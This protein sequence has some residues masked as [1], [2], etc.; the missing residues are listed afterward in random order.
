MQNTSQ[1][2]YTYMCDC[3]TATCSYYSGRLVTSLVAYIIDVSMAPR[4]NRCVLPS[5]S[6][7]L[8]WIRSTMG[9]IPWGA[10]PQTSSGTPRR[11]S[12]AYRTSQTL[13][14][15]RSDPVVCHWMGIRVKWAGCEIL[16]WMLRFPE[17]QM[18]ETP[19]S[20]T[21]PSRPFTCT[22]FPPASRVFLDS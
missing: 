16:S 9:S 11:S 12:M 2:S 22:Y 4:L 8:L 20:P 10:R 15:W 19:D 17:G 1:A 3:P 5:R 21:A 6:F 14:V 18:L 7:M 13:W